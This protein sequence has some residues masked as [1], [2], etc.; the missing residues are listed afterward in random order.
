MH[1]AHTKHN[2][3]KHQASYL[4]SGFRVLFVFWSLCSI[5]ILILVLCVRLTTYI[6]Q[7][8]AFLKFVILNL[9]SISIFS[10]RI[11]SKGR[12]QLLAGA[13]FFVAVAFPSIVFAATFNDAA[14]GNWNI[15]DTWGTGCSSSCTEGTHYPGSGDVVTI[16]SHTV[17]LTADQSTGS[18]TI[19]G[20]TLTF[21]SYTLSG[22]SHWAYDTGTINPGTGTLSI[23]GSGTTFSGGGA[24]YYNLSL[25]SVACCATALSVLGTTTIQNNLTLSNHNGSGYQD[26]TFG[27]GGTLEAQG[28]ILLRWS[29]TRTNQD[30]KV[31][32]NGTVDQ[33]I[34]SVD[35]QIK[36]PVNLWIDKTGGTLTLTTSLDV[37]ND[38]IYQNGTVDMGTST[39][40]FIGHTVDILGGDMLFNHLELDN[41]GC[42]S[43]VFNFVG[44]TTIAGDF[45]IT[46]AQG[47][48]SPG[49]GLTGG[50][51]EVH[52]DIVT[53]D[54]NVP[55]N[56]STALKIFV[57]GTGNQ[58]MYGTSENADFSTVYINKPSGVLTFT[59]NFSVATDFYYTTGDVDPGTS[60][61]QFVS[62]TAIISAE[63]MPFYDLRINNA[64]CCSA[65]STLVGT[66]TVR[67][68]Y[69]MTSWANNAGL[70]GGS[71]AIGGD[72]SITDADGTLTTGFYLNGTGAQEI[73]IGLSVPSS[74]T[75]IIDK[76]SGIA[77]LGRA[78]TADIDYNIESGTFDQDGFD[79]DVED[80]TI[81][82]SGTWL[83]A[84]STSVTTTISSSVTNNG[85]IY[86][87]GGGNSCGDS[88]TLTIA[89]SSG[90]KSWSGTG[91]TTI[92]DATIS[93]MVG[94]HTVLVSSGTDGGSNG[95]NFTFDSSCPSTVKQS[96]YRWFKNADSVAPGVGGQLNGKDFLPDSG[97]AFRLRTLLDITDTALS[98]SGE[99]FKLQ[100]AEKVNTCDGYNHV[101][102]DV[103]TGS[104][105]LRYNDN[106]SVADG[107]SLTGSSLLGYLGRTVNLQTYEES[108]NFTNSASSISTS[109]EG[110]WDF[111]LSNNSVASGSGTTYCF[112]V[113][114][115][116]GG[117]LLDDYI[118]VAEI[119][120]TPPVH[121]R[122]VGQVRLRTVRLR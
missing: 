117:A 112:R 9:F 101:Y 52:G 35:G 53:S 57:V 98:S 32:V 71:L 4:C 78:H 23:T 50:S 34:F 28:D 3:Q 74:G 116:S 82:T 63:G 76:P 69:S 79:L 62:G 56:G 6:F 93:G 67:N 25:A 33:D 17:T 73:S 89:P 42:C 91:T 85:V 20:G 72:I 87:N 37:A 7:R 96:A 55:D 105:V 75:F 104:G 45:I 77:T 13:V 121:I 102:S 14:D 103:E 48:P 109:E 92:K 38:W 1:K 110:E 22:N 12:I 94:T 70:V 59:D 120:S 51:V 29:N 111:A 16:D 83:N 24:T 119:Q 90:T 106:A 19:S 39:I 108:N 97:G 80:I 113:V 21:D 10:F 15:G 11:C 5:C 58:S 27:G 47:S 41:N 30:L 18:T 118:Q 2:T 49:A 100:F 60:R 46:S 95:S 115:A 114:K 84:S 26:S 61:V 36:F 65:Q 99:N 86:F 54:T 43:A 40:R 8:P 31:L 81:G 44:T 107:A 66:T 88:D 68:E 122:L 64:S